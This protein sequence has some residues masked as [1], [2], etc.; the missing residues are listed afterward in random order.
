MKKIIKM[1]T[2]MLIN[3]VIVKGCH[4]IKEAAKKLLDSYRIFYAMCVESASP[5]QE[6]LSVLHFAC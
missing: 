4:K 5:I 6:N 1:T 3:L 2:P